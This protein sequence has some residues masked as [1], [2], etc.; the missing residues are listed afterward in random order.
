MSTM[1][2]SGQR[3]IDDVSKQLHEDGSGRDAPHRQVRATIYVWLSVLAVVAV[4]V[5]ILGGVL[6]WLLAG[7]AAD[8]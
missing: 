2:S 5:I 4:M 1:S 3:I 8:P 6:A 7:S